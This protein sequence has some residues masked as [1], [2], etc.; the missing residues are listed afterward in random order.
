[1]KANIT[2]W[3]EFSSSS[4]DWAPP[5]SGSLEANLD[6]AICPNFAVAAAVLSDHEGN[7]I[8]ASS[9]RLPPLEAS[10]GEA[11]AALLSINLVLFNGCFSLFLEGDSLLSI[12]ATNKAHL[13]TDWSCAAIISDIH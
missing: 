1:V 4:E 7:I 8:A 13:F 10:I 12:L 5:P 11:Q 2:A 6:V 9:K 3:R